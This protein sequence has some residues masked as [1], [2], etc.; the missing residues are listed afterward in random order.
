[1]VRTSVEHGTNFDMAGT[2]ASDPRSLIGA[3][4]L[5]ATMVRGRA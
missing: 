2:G 3:L 4:E 5:G 1:M